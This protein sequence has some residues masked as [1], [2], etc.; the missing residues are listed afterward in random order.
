MAKGDRDNRGDEDVLSEDF[1]ESRRRELYERLPK[2]SRYRHCLGVAEQSA[3]M[4]RIYGAD[5]RKARLA[6]L[7]HDWDKGYDDEGI[8]ERASQ[9][10]LDEDP[11]VMEKMPQ[12]LH[13]PT[14]AAALKKRFPQLPG[15]VVS[16]IERHTAGAVDMSDLDMIVYIAD[17]IEPN[18][19]FPGVDRLR[20]KVGEE[21]LEELFVDVSGNVLGNLIE[22]RRFVHP[23][24]LKVW[25]HYI[26][27]RK[28]GR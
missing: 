23:G 13:G 5:E 20:A 26:A 28:S 27:R 2:K 7:L 8:R 6:G 14:A 25:N 10:G 17:V 12:L 19:D 15:D 3:R 22:R 18:R 4:A 11:F 24:T 21:S 9:L 1:Y 16:A